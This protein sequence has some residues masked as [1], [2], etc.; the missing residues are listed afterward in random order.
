LTDAFDR[1]GVDLGGIVLEFGGA[2]KFA[3]DIL[4]VVKDHNVHGQHCA[5]SIKGF[6]QGGQTRRTPFLRDQW[7]RCRISSAASL[8]SSAHTS[9]MRPEITILPVVCGPSAE[10]R[11][12]KTLR[13]GTF[14]KEGLFF[15]P[16]EGPTWV[17]VAQLG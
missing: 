14:D 7:L 10:S 12:R 9:A 8:S 2:L 3:D 5:L 4:V 17:L 13:Q 15:G 6:W 11:T 1:V 16:F